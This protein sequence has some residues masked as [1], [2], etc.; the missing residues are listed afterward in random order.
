[1]DR[2]FFLDN[3]NKYQ[4]RKSNK[5]LFTSNNLDLDLKQSNQLDQQNINLFSKNDYSLM[6]NKS[7]NSIKDN[8]DYL[9]CVN[10][11]C[12][13][14]DCTCNKESCQCV[15][16]NDLQNNSQNNLEK[17]FKNNNLLEKSKKNYRFDFKNFVDV[18]LNILFI[19]I[20]FVLSLFA[21]NY[22]KSENLI[23]I[24]ILALVFIFYKIFISR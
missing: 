19:I 17:Y 14:I 6:N 4:Q 5:I 10:G 9:G 15:T 21:F 7:F 16:E 23:Y 20:V 22:R 2:H 13:S 1:M 18:L 12:K 3:S 11:K 8:I 24:L